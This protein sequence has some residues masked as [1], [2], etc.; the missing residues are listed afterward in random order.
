VPVSHLH[1]VP[2]T[3]SLL[4]IS[5]SYPHPH[6]SCPPPL[7]LP[8]P[9][10]GMQGYLL[11]LGD[12]SVP[13]S[14]IVST[15]VAPP[16]G[17]RDVD[18]VRRA[19]GR[20]LAPLCF[21]ARF[22]RPPPPIP[23]LRPAPQALSVASPGSPP[24]GL[25]VC[26]LGRRQQRAGATLGLFALPDSPSPTPVVGSSPLSHLGFADQSFTGTGPCLGPYQ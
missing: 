3:P 22:S 14:P 5:V 23:T 6:P 21:V 2:T 17:T 18:A 24:V 19:F 26:C 4:G 9:H 20:L 25:S 16:A 11:A 10:T 8:H 12:I 7:P 1:G 15:A 13:V